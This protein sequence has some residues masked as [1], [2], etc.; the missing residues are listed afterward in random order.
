MFFVDEAVIHVKGGDGGHGCVSFRRERYV[1]RGGP[2]GGDGG[3]GGNVI[4]RVSP[5]VD[6]LIDLSSRVEY[7]AQNGRHGE[8]STRHGRSGKDLVIELPVGTVIKDKETG[9]VLKDL[10]EPGQWVKIAR[11]GRGGRGNKHFATST[12]RAPRFAEKGQKGQERWLRLE[13][14]LF[15][16]VGIIGM[17]N[18]G[19]STLLSKVSRAHPKIADY[20]FTTLY[21][22]LGIVEIAD[23][24]R[25]VVADL[26]GLILG[27]HSGVGLGDEFLRHTERTKILLHLID[28]APLSGPD[29]VKAYHIIR[30]ELELY[31]PEL[32]KKREIIAANK[33]D[34]LDEPTCL[35]K[36]KYLEKKLSLPVYPISAITG[37]N[38]P[39]LLE[40]IAKTLDELSQEKK[41]EEPVTLK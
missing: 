16:D 14:K 41:V 29:P 2:D 20:P 26:P 24:R 13:L 1:P 39:A 11:G 9:R 36:V 40:V 30:K 4:L 34:L 12:N 28:I 5:N 17:P 23:F 21:P 22:Q 27:A 10:Q 18:V 35:E 15:A 19:K 38:L 31:S 7:V 25:I 33:I 6:T 8:G 3:R 37:K 32:S